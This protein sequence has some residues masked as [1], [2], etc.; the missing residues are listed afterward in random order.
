M[1]FI[2]A[3]LILIGAT[4]GINLISSDFDKQVN[5]T[6]QPVIQFVSLYIVTGLVYFIYI[7][8]IKNFR[9]K[10]NNLIIWIFIIGIVLRLLMIFSVPILEVDYYRYLW[11]GAVTT[12]GNNPYKY[13]PVQLFNVNNSAPEALKELALKNENI[14][15]RINH[16]YLKTS[17]PP[18]TQTF[19]AISN[20]LKPFSLT[21][22]KFILLFIDVITFVLVFLLL[23]KLKIPES[24]L[25]IYWWNPLLIKEVFNSGHMDILIF[26]FLLACFLLYLSNKYLISFAALSTAV[27]A[28][29]WPVL[30]FPVLIRKFIPDRKK[31]F[32]NFC[33]FSVL[34]FI[35]LFPIFISYFD[36]GSGIE[37]YTRSWQN[38]DSIFRIVLATSELVLPLIGYHPGHGQ[39][40]SRIVVGCL[41]I[42][43]V[44]YFSKDKVKKDLDYIKT[45]LII[46]A[47][48]FFLSP[49]QFP[50]YFLWMIPFLT[51][52]PYKPLLLLTVLMPLYYLR[53]YYE[54]RGEY[55]FYYQYVVWIEY[56]PVLL[57]IG[58]DLISKKSMKRSTA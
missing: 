8:R 31:F 10:I 28:K 17:Y 35:I 5:V 56:L 38:N 13:S 15:K 51:F 4:V 6:D 19:F 18:V 34:T 26:P 39:M 20:L 1:Y 32:Q 40:L 55:D 25:L 11:D 2:I 12:S 41:V 52:I 30:I 49:T 54:P 24:N 46:T 22:W 3:G 7:N 37:A 14:V 29:L 58:Y 53:Y 33:I 57:W 44:L 36:I 47:V 21:T 43:A 45:A 23:K 48:T 16:P 27:G 42:L 9:P 50:W